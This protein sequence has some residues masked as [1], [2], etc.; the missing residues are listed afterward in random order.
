MWRVKVDVIGRVVDHHALERLV[1]LKMTVRPVN[2]DAVCLSRNDRESFRVSLSSG[3]RAMGEFEGSCSS[4][5]F[6]VG[7]VD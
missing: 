1:L 6:S 3:G 7:D 5:V 4:H 2:G